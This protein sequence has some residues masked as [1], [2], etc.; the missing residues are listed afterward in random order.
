MWTERRGRIDHVFLAQGDVGEVPEDVQQ[1]DV[2]LL[3]AVDG[4]AGDGEAVLGRILQPP[5]ILAAEADGKHALGTGHLERVNQ[6][7]RM[8]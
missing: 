7:G 3:D 5:A 1:R 8:A 4:E 6:V 2:R